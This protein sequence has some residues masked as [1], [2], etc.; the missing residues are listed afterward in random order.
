MLNIKAPVHFQDLVNFSDSS[1]LECF[2]CL[3]K[4][5]INC[6][7]SVLHISA[8]MFFEN[9]EVKQKWQSII[10]DFAFKSGANKKAMKINA[11]LNNAEKVKANTMMIRFLWV[12][13]KSLWK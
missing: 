5:A 10:N 4:E 2:K 12:S 6:K 8:H 7:T 3:D 13:W 9:T 1:N 11:T